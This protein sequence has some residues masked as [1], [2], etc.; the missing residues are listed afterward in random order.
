MLGIA[1][2]SSA[3][4]DHDAALKHFESLV[5]WA[6]EREPVVGA[7]NDFA[8]SVVLANAR[9][10]LEVDAY[11]RLLRYTLD[12]VEP[13][14]GHLLPSYSEFVLNQFDAAADPKAFYRAFGDDVDAALERLAETRQPGYR[15]LLLTRV[16]LTQL[17]L[18]RR[19]AVLETYRLVLEARAEQHAAMSV[20]SLGGAPGAAWG[21][22]P[23]PQIASS[24]LAYRRLLGLDGPSLA[25]IDP[26]TIQ[27][28]LQ[29]DADL[30]ALLFRDADR[31]WLKQAEARI[32]G[33]LDADEMDRSLAIGMLLS[34][35]RAYHEAGH[36]GRL[37]ELFVYLE[38]QLDV[39]DGLTPATAA[40]IVV[41]A[42]ELDYE[43]DR[44][45]LD[46]ELL[47]LGAIEPPYMAA[48]LR[49]IAAAEGDTAALDVGSA[50]L[51]F[52]LEDRLLDELIALADAAGQA[53]RA[54]EWRVLQGKARV[55][56]KE[57]A[58]TGAAAELF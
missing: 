40:A 21:E 27:F 9:A 45:A 32:R 48:A 39:G 51:E 26:R 13:L 12:T 16:L 36:D 23:S 37:Q 8:L 42:D 41:A 30:S 57:L 58:R 15:P 18:G 10:I 14:E 47:G 31:A 50:L 19:Q 33:W 53:T 28:L 52:T 5:H 44:P 3:S 6:R 1:E 24:T 17:A 38:T 49:R 34:L 7:A 29:P 55:A 22:T 46:R 54:E 56:R 11:E 25:Q 35:A 4:G 20:Q 43:L 2:L